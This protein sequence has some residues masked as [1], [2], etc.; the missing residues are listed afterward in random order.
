M[1]SAPPHFGFLGASPLFV[2]LTTVS[3]L[4]C[5]KIGACGGLFLSGPPPFLVPAHFVGGE[6]PAHF[7]FGVP[8]HLKNPKYTPDQCFFIK[9]KPEILGDRIVANAREDV[10]SM[11]R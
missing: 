10:M 9:N 3:P 11:M 7:D 2:P 4:F 8:A 6:F 1:K 5:K